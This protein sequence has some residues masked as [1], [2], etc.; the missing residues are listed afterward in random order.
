MNCQEGHRPDF[1]TD[2]KTTLC[3]LLNPPCVFLL[4]VFPLLTEV[5]V[6]NRVA[7]E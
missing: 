1:Y 7:G 5:V 6:G 4:K 2:G 3:S